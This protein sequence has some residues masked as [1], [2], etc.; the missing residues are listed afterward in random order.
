LR[1]NPHLA[2]DRTKA[3]GEYCFNSGLGTMVHLATEPERTPEDVVYE[4]DGLI[5]AGLDP[6]RFATI[7]GN[8]PN[9]TWRMV[10]PP[11]GTA[12]SASRTRHGE[13]HNCNCD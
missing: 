6:A 1:G 5:A 9:D 13:P 8:R 2:I 11:K 4:F 3:S 7:T 10:F 12:R